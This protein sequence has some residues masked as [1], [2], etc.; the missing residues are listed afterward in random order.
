MQRRG[1]ADIDAKKPSETAQL[2]NIPEGKLFIK[3]QL[4]GL[5]TKTVRDHSECRTQN[6]ECLVHYCLHRRRIVLG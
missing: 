6:F 4:K 5:L 1:K 3:S 2:G